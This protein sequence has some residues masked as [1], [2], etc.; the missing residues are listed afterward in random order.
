MVSYSLPQPPVSHTPDELHRM[1]KV[2]WEIVKYQ[3]GRID[4]LEQ[5]TVTGSTE[6]SWVTSL[7]IE[8]ENS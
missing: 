1:V 7:K 5:F 8:L 2:L 4:E 6:P 3:E